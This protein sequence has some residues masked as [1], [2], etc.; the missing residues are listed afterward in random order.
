[1]NAIRGPD[2]TGLGLKKGCRALVM[3]IIKNDD[4]YHRKNTMLF[5]IHRNRHL[6]GM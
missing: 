3:V 2:K 5:I 1:M 6:N 4:L